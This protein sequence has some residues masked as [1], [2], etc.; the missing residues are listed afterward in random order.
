MPEK[1]PRI[2]LRRTPCLALKERCAMPL[3]FFMCASCKSH[4][5]LSKNIHLDES[6]MEFSVRERLSAMPLAVE[7]PS[8]SND[9]RTSIRRLPAGTLPDLLKRTIPVAAP[10]SALFLRRYL[11]RSQ[12]VPR[13]SRNV[14]VKA[15]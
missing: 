12:G 7:P 15:V 6:G 2:A 10:Q 5:T 13:A 4:P 11:R 8:F 9:N 1:S 14:A 3:F